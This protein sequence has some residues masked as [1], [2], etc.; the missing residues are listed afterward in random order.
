MNII[1]TCT[2]TG[3]DQD[4]PGTGEI[5]ET[6]QCSGIIEM[7]GT[8]IMEITVTGVVEMT[9]IIGEETEE[10]DSKLY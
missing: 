7:T 5:T 4:I 8:G 2:T 10:I 9:G 6:S 3:T 1:H